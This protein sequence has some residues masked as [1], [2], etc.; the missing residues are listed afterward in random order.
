M[1]DRS[2]R[3]RLARSPGARS[4]VHASPAENFAVLHRHEAA[5]LEDRGDFFVMEEQGASFRRVDGVLPGRRH[6]ARNAIPAFR[7]MRAHAQQAHRPAAGRHRRHPFA[8]PAPRE[9]RQSLLRSPV[10]AL[11]YRSSFPQRFPDLNAARTFCRSSFTWYNGEHRYSGI[12]MLTPDTVH[13]GKAPACL[14]G[15]R[16]DLVSDW[17]AP[18][19]RYV[20]GIPR[21]RE[22]SE[23]VWFNPL[24]AGCKTPLQ[25]DCPTGQGP[26]NLYRQSFGLMLSR[27][28]RLAL[29]MAARFQ[30]Q[31]QAAPCVWDHFPVPIGPGGAGGSAPCS[32][33]P[34]ASAPG[35]E[36]R[37]QP[38]HRQS[39]R[40]VVMLNQ[41]T[42]L[43]SQCH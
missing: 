1:L 37:R 32:E 24:A 5:F 3:L 39:C 13:Y 36:L 8:E 6:P 2:K 12:A 30:R 41:L 25:P 14:E 38:A 35:W 40:C 17:R 23:A 11:K 19:E 10:Q 22:L 18:P 26:D 15:R 9:R 33:G 20:H 31:R 7:P 43:V 21:P 28:P 27:Q 29:A 42:D 4:G 16:P 34:G